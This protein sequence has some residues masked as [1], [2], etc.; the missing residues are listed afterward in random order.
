MRLSCE[1]LQQFVFSLPMVQECD[2]VKNGAL[3]LS[4]PF[5]YPNG[6]HIDVFLE[7]AHSLYGG[8]S[9]SDYG[10]TAQ[11][12][13]D[14]NSGISSSGRKRQIL[15]DILHQF[16]VKL[17]NGDLYIE[18]A[19]AEVAEIS[20]AMLKLTQACVRISEFSVHQRQRAT[21]PF[22]EDVAGFLE[23]KSLPFAS[24]VK[25]QGK[26]DNDIRID[27]AVHGPQRLSYVLL[28]TPTTEQGS[29]SSSNEIFR[30]W[31][32]LRDI[33]FNRVTVFNSVS[34]VRGDDI[35]R[36]REQSRVVSY[37]KQEAELVSILS[38]QAA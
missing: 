14:W 38:G 29:H 27:F 4:T 20:A 35:L 5:V 18:I 21:N 26:F 8:Y 30:K 19:P 31:Y 24:D 22:R 12:V 25:V 2:V 15:G 28:L 16:G 33:P 34:P 6:D 37:P 3:R 23:T 13:K 9:I 36:L 7:P 1:N 17:R 10:Q 11:Y 32:D